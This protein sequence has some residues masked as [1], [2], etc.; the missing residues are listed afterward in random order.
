MPEESRDARLQSE[1]ILRGLE[2]Y[3]AD[4]AILFGSYVRGE[5]DQRSDIDLIV[6]KRTEKRFLDRLAE[7]IEIIQPDFA[8][9]VFACSPEEFGRMME[10]DN[11]FLTH[12]V[13]EGKVIYER[14]EGRRKAVARAGNCDGTGRVG[15]GRSGN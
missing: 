15:V 2:V 1:P 8:F 12:A 14:P 3:E 4:K 9:D 10:D 7:I 13:A 6:I 11:P 5:A